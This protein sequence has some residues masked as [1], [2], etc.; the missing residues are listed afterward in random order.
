MYVSVRRAKTVTRQRE[1]KE[2]MTT[3]TSVP[4]FREMLLAPVTLRRNGL[5]KSNANGSVLV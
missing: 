1:R 4:P 5:I 3:M 2:V